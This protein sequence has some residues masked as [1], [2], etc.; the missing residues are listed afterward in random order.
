MK[1]RLLIL[2]LLAHLLV[3]CSDRQDAVAIPFVAVFGEQDL[4]C[5]RAGDITELSDLRFYVSNLQLITANGESVDVRLKA[6]GHW[7]QSDLALLDF[8]DGTGACVNGTSATNTILLGT[9]PAAEYQGL[10]FTVGVPFER[11]HADPLKAEA[12]LADA[13]MHWHWRAGYKFLRAGIRTAGDSF[14]MHLGSA[15]CEGTVRNISA[16]RFPN[17]VSVHLEEFAPGTDVVAVDLAA[18]VSNAEL[19]DAMATDCSSG[20]AETA[21]VAPFSA[22]GLD[23]GTGSP[24]YEQ[25]VFRKKVKN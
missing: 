25:R 1:Q 8:E 21:C 19:E 22:L 18:I 16:C 23:F 24:I 17:R 6:D 14:W 9:V 15:G 5:G 20:P 12:P 7:Q 3:A 10:S 4:S 13:A 11:N 2:F